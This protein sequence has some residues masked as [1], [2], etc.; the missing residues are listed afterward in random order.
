MDLAAAE[1]GCWYHSQPDYI[2]ARESD[3]KAFRNVGFQQPRFHDSDHHAVVDYIPWGRM[4]R[5]KKYCRGRQ[6]FPLQLALLGEQDEVTR[7]FGRLR[8]ECQEKDPTKRP[9]N[10][11]ISKETWR[12]IPQRAMLRRTN[13]LCQTGGR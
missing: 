1:G 10:N 9:W 8:E 6:K 11:W 13:H 3:G 2:M 4:G 7:L 5:I 12:L